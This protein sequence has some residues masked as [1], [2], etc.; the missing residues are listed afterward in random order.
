MIVRNPEGEI[1]IGRRNVHPQPDWWYVL[2]RAL[3]FLKAFSLRPVIKH[4]T[5]E[6]A[7]LIGMGQIRSVLTAGRT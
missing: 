4:S 7:L 2:L 5:V 1:L 6:A 3:E